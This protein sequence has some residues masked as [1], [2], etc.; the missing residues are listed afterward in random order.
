MVVKNHLQPVLVLQV[1][2]YKNVFLHPLQQ[3]KDIYI[4]FK[5]VQPPPSTKKPQHNNDNTEEFIKDKKEE[6]AHSLTIS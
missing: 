3:Q 1:K 6:I 4:E 2:M 5:K